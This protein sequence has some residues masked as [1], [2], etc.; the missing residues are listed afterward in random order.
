M[1]THSWENLFRDLCAA[2]IADALEENTFD[3]KLDP[4]RVRVDGDRQTS[5]LGRLVWGHLSHTWD[6][7]NLP[8][9]FCVW[10]EG[11]TCKNANSPKN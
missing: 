1:V 5:W 4:M 10:Q 8:F 6:Q 2:V 7:C 11:V 3:L 9:D